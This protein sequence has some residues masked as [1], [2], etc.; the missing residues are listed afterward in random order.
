[1][2]IGIL[3]KTL[4]SLFVIVNAR[5]YQSDKS[6]DIGTINGKKVSQLHFGEMYGEYDGGQYYFTTF[7]DDSSLYC[8]R[9]GCIGERTKLN[10]DGILNDKTS[11]SLLNELRERCDEMNS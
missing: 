2:G 3:L 1:M 6:L 9:T 4:F 10:D 7:K 8:D 11:A 5:T